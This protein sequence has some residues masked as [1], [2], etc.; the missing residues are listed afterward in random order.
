MEKKVNIIYTAKPVLRQPYMVCGIDSWINSGEALTGSVKYLIRQF[1]AKKF[2]EIPASPYHIYQVP[3]AD[4]LRP[5]TRTEDGLIMEYHFP[6]NQFFY[7]RNPASDHDLILFLGNEPNLNWED[8]AASIVRLAKEFQ[9]ARLYISG[10]ILDETPHTR[11]LRVSCS[12]TSAEVRKEMRKYNVTFSNSIGPITF[13][14]IVL[15]FCQIN[16]IEAVSL[17]TRATYYPEFNILIPYNP[18]SIKAILVWLNHLMHLNLDF[19]RLNDRIKDFE[20]KLELMRK[21]S[22]RFN[23]YVEELE[24]NYVEMPYQESLDISPDDAIKLAEDIL[25]KNK[26]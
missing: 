17:W 14:T 23:A 21:Q 10:A 4:Y 13:Y 12:C 1:S 20:G 26:G 2:A 15:Y 11:E 7:A 16:C 22:P 9:V 8:Y 18:K 3:G 25:K 24:K 6:R 5:V 19:D